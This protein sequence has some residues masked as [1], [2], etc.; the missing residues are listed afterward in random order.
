M[1]GHPKI[2]GRIR[3]IGGAKMEDEICNAII[4]VGRKGDVRNEFGEHCGS[5][6]GL[7]V[8]FF[9]E[10]E[11]GGIGVMILLIG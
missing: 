11:N 10:R 1:V 5:G 8:D 6:C 9:I 3:V 7:S 4:A 2:N